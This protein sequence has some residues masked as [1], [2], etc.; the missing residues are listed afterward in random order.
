MSKRLHVLVVEDSPA[1]VDLIREYM[2]D[3]GF[4]SF[5]IDSAARLSEAITRLGRES[6]DLLLIDLGLP[7][8]R[9]L[10]TFDSLRKAAPNTPIIILTGYDDEGTAMTAVRNGAQDYLIKGEIIRN[11][12]VRAAQYAVERKRA[13]AELQERESKLKTL[14]EILPVGVSILDAENKITFL[15]SALGRILEISSEDLLRGD[16]KNRTYLR[17]DGTPM[18]AKEFASAQAIAKQRAVHNVVTGVV[19]EDGNIIWTS[20]SAIPVEF[21][22]WKAVIVTADITKHKRAE[23]EVRKSEER[24]KLIFGF[25]PDAYY[26][27]DL[28]G[29]F[30]DGNRAAEKTTGYKREELIGGSFLKLNLLSLDQLPKAAKLLAKNALGMATGPDEFILK[31]KAGDKVHVEISTHPVKFENKTIVLGIA[32]D[33][34]ERIEREGAL[35]QAE[36]NFRR[37][38]DD[39]PLGIRIVSAKGETLY[40]NQAILD[41]YGYEDIEELRSTP[42]KIR[43]TPE[44]YAEYQSRKKKRMNGEDYP[45]EYEINILRKTGEIRCLRI[46][47]KEVIWN[48]KKQFQA[49]CQDVTEQKKSEEKLRE[50]LIDLRNALSGIIQVLSATTEKRDPYTA[51]HQR[52]VADLARAIGEEMGLAKERVEGL[53]IAGTIHD[54]GKISI[55]AEILSK[56]SCL[57]DIEYQMIQSH[58]QV[59]HDILGNIDFHWPVATTILQHHERMNGSGYPLRLK[60]KDIL[61]EAR[62]LGVS[63]VVEAMASHRPYRPALGIEAALEEI[64]KNKDVL[65]DPDVA[66]ACLKLFRA[67]GFIFKA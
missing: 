47:R 35:R 1:D 24:F 39:S 25:A 56:P 45:P 46:F 21:P 43:Y 52:R 64:D 12:L 14:F 7:D 17:S 51:G 38:M 16:Y 57:T 37:S 4:I 5:Q 22:D 55:P 6:F 59:G 28:K 48:G 54:I 62:I 41:M 66:A 26:L 15:N 20:V 13:E 31:Q 30:V 2:F 65:Y 27:N 3:S 33:I 40:A 34:T 32:R 36:E 67:K 10:N 53:R 9:G 44:S 23:E 50:T 58:P 60:G 8:S 11:T 19:K 63:D 49:I 42:V 29:N 61:L 18:A